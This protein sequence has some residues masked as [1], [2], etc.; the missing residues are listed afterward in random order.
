MSVGA[1]AVGGG[2]GGDES[3]T[4]VL[5]TSTSTSGT[6]CSPLGGS[7]TTSYAAS[8]YCWRIMEIGMYNDCLMDKT[9][10]N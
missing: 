1:E 4:G 8:S 2:D 7:S 9:C 5:S 6:G 3:G 10:V